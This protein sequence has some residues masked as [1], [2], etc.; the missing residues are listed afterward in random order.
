MTR[1]CELQAGTITR[2]YPTLRIASLRLHYSVPERAYAL[3]PNAVRTSKD[4]FDLWGYVQE[5]S[6]ADA[7][8]LAITCDTTSWPSKHEAF[9][10]VAPS[11][12]ADKDSA[13]LKREYYPDIP[14]RDG[15][16][17]TGRRSFFDCRKA[18]KLLGWVHR[19]V[20]PE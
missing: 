20:V 12:A 8:L 10:V 15:F 19:D 2:R 18:E 16:E 1:I 9:L 5:D 14:V 17:I 13:E 7:F 6:A 11:S 4:S 3:K